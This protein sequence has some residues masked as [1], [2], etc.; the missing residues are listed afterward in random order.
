MS[1]VTAQALG[2]Y[3]GAQQVL[4]GISFAIA[5]G[6]RIALV[7][8]NG[9]GKT[10]ILRILMGLEEPSEGGISRARGLRLGYLPQRAA[11]ESERTVFDEM[12]TLFEGLR[13]QQQAL[14]EL[15]EAMAAQ[16]DNAE[17]MARYA[18]AEARFDLAGGYT[19]ENRIQRVLTGLGFQRESYTWPIRVLSGGQ[20][21]RALLAKLLLQEPE[22]LVLDEPTNYLDLEALEWLE[23]YL[24]SWPQTLLV[25]SHDR[26]FLDKVATRVWELNR[27]RLETY[28]G[29]YSHYVAQREAR[30][31]RQERE[32]EAQQES[33]AK[34]EDFIRR[35][36][37]GQRSREAKGR[38][39][40][41]ERLERLEAPQQERSM[42]LR[43]GTELRSGDQVLICEAGATIGYPSKPG[44]DA[45]GEGAPHPLFRTGPF[46]VQ[47]G[48]R[49]ALLGPNGSGKTTFVRTL[50][51]QLRPLEGR[52]RIG[53]S[54]RIGYLPQTQDWLDPTLSVLDQVLSASPLQPD[55]ARHVL[56][57]FLF[58]GDEVFK[59][60][61]TLSGGEL[62]RLGLCLLTLRGANLLLLDE[63]T[64]HLD[65]DS[66]EVLQRVLSGFPGTI[67]LVSHDRY[68]I[69][70]M[71]THVWEV[72]DGRLA[73][74]EGNYSA[75]QAAKQRAQQV[76]QAE[77]ERRQQARD[78]ERR[79]LRQEQL[80]LRRRDARLEE[81]EVEIERLEREVAATTEELHRAS[82]RQD[83]QRVHALGLAYT[84]TQQALA[85]RLEEWEQIATS[86]ETQL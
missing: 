60:T 62:S 38:E 20:V 29:N 30:Q 73:Q 54:V 72:G 22:L 37:A 15:A 39:K 58:T 50:L 34:T 67:L 76:M 13:Q 41:L 17:L 26:Y 63:P 6:D 81:L 43:L 71:A 5:H 9:A 44:T 84:Q 48:D 74:Y 77:P 16:A 33:I 35:Y 49:V 79:R 59:L 24:Q 47:R 36:K 45:E 8:P 51:R 86:A 68:L 1:I 7:G 56:A 70:A 19:Y 75:Y 53:A 4:S 42:S 46:L 32:F 69:D 31:L 78:E 28:H 55:E 21:T 27:G 52:I 23:A 10:T 2:K 40:R 14:H 12:L 80:A 25:V 65:V 18:E 57:R 82:E 3:Y 64:T 85:E 11:M 66:Q 61:G 83:G